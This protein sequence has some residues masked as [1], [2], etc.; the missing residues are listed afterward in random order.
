MPKEQ[1]NVKQTKKEKDFTPQDKESLR[2]YFERIGGEDI[3]FVED[4]KEYSMPRVKAERP[5]AIN[6][7]GS[8]I[9]N[10]QN[11]GNY[12]S[13]EDIG[14]IE[15]IKK[16]DSPNIKFAKT[17]K[18]YQINKEAFENPQK[19]L[20]AITEIIKKEKGQLVID[21]RAID[22]VKEWNYE[23]AQESE[24]EEKPKKKSEKPKKKTKSKEKP[25]KKSEK[26]KKKKK[27]KAPTLDELIEKK[28]KEI[29]EI[30]MGYN[31]YYSPVVKS[32]M[33]LYYKEEYKGLDERRKELEDLEKGRPAAPPANLPIEKETV[34]ATETPSAEEMPE[35]E[36]IPK[37]EGMP[38]EL[39]IMPEKLPTIK[40]YLYS[41]KHI[42]NL[43]FE[44]AERKKVMKEKGL[45]PKI[46]KAKEVAYRIKKK[47]YGEAYEK[48]G[49]TYNMLDKKE[50]RKA[51][52]AL[53]VTKVEK[54]GKGLWTTGE[55][56]DLL[57]KKEQKKT[58]FAL[59]LAKVE[60]A[61][62]RFWK[63][64]TKKVGKE[65]IEE[66]TKDAIDVQL[67]V[68]KKD[69]RKVSK[70]IEEGGVLGRVNLEKERT[71]LEKMKEV[72]EERIEIEKRLKEIP[73]EIKEIG[74]IG[75][76]DLEKEQG[77]LEKKLKK[78]E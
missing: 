7:D 22:A 10:D 47:E 27:E 12:F 29:E 35:S 20:E 3:E 4:L 15:N 68:I 48:F 44:M 34:K 37:S 55:I 49:E 62:K 24:K 63:L 57:G 69:L 2:K 33:S 53:F 70:G 14:K 78:L 56:Y 73:E 21:W 71:R 13:E 59:F 43:F 6:S 72:I 66:V 39:P 64:F 77:R 46:R 36:E 23:E 50:R 18:E 19:Y 54:V 45:D 9:V 67:K 51:M 42:H 26:P 32:L 40:D 41:F 17:T 1:P 11:I 60:K 58:T 25:K 31:I 30:E 76:A 38:E 75:R 61:E 5:L 28:K 74:V 65:T 8:W 52:F 16:T